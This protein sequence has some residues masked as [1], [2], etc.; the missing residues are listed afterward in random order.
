MTYRIAKPGDII[1]EAQ[2]LYPKK[3]HEV[4]E[5]SYMDDVYRKAAIM[6]GIR[7]HLKATRGDVNAADIAGG[8]GRQ[9]RIIRSLVKEDSGRVVI[10]NVDIGR[11]EF[12]RGRGDERTIGDVM[13][14]PLP[15][16][17]MDFVFMNNIPIPLSHVKYYVINMKDET[18][19]KSRFLRC[20]RMQSMPS[21]SSICWRV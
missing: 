20:L 16:K 21:T 9:G 18:G 19:K 8:S 14:L 13:H 2:K 4:S 12:R 3:F 10:H 1:V 11:R 15:D 5:S 6:C 7:E 17:S